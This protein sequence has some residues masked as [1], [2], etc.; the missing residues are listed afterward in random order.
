M[1][2]RWGRGFAI[3]TRMSRTRVYVGRNVLKEALAAHATIHEIFVETKSAYEWLESLPGLKNFRGKV[4]EGIPK[5][6]RSEAHQGIAFRT[7]HEFYAVFD[8][9]LL[10]KHDFI[11]CCNHIE[12]VHNLGS[13]VRSAAAFGAGLVIHEDDHSAS[14]TE[15]AVKASAGCAFRIQL[16]KVQKLESALNLIRSA[17]FEIWGLEAKDSTEIYDLK[18]PRR[19][20]LVCGAESD[21][22]Q[23]SVRSLCQKRVRIPMMNGVDSLNVSHAAAIAMSWISQGRPSG[24]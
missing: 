12:D 9:S 15:G 21:G 23:D 13:I 14:M 3:R 8:S 5:A 24:R 11:I 2:C 10:T 6:L 18:P 16:A 4:E 17:G 1:G 19:L 20:A 7:N 22:L